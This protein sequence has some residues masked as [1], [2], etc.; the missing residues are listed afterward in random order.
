MIKSRLHAG[1][2]PSMSASSR[3]PSSQATSE[4]FTK[5]RLR[6]KPSTPRLEK[7]LML[8]YTS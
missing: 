7:E 2:Q 6:E 5:I 1:H 4:L 3:V 8:F